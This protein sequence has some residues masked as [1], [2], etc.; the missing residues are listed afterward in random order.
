MRFP[1]FYAA[2]REEVP[3]YVQAAYLQNR[4]DQAAA[5][6]DRMLRQERANN[7]Q[8]M[9]TGAMNVA[10]MDIGDGKTPMSEFIRMGKE[11]W[12]SGAAQNPAAPSAGEISRGPPPVSSALPKAGIGGMQ[13]GTALPRAP[14]P[15]PT[16]R[17]SAVGDAVREADPGVWQAPVTPSDTVPNVK[18]PSSTTPPMPGYGPGP[19]AAASGPTAESNAALLKA[20]KTN[21][22]PDMTASVG[23]AG[24]RPTNAALTAYQRLEC[25]YSCR[26]YRSWHPGSFYEHAWSNIFE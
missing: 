3:S 18:L 8:A 9:G 4:S 2:K 7:I 14:T 26:L 13:G 6:E 16:G 11:K 12:G 23:N 10:G 22:T 5:A 19:Q 15:T 21:I 25:N 1:D 20:Y 24:A 17:G